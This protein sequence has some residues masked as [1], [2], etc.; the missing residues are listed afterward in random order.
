MNK[1]K[2]LENF[3]NRIGASRD[4]I[5]ITIG[6]KMVKDGSVESQHL[7][8]RE[9][10]K[11]KSFLKMYYDDNLNL[12]TKNPERAHK[13]FAV[14]GYTGVHYS[15]AD[16]EKLEDKEPKK[17][18][19]KIEEVKDEVDSKPKIVNKKESFKEGE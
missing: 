2:D 7:Q 1:F 3:C 18:K 16:L 4:F 9:I 5:G 10:D 13:L 6:K 17:E 19:D 11:V 14:K 12:K 8:Y 15:F